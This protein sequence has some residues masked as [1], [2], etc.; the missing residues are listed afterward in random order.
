MPADSRCPVCDGQQFR[1]RAIA[2]ITIRRCLG[3]GLR[4]S[5]IPKKKTTGYATIDC[6]AYLQS[7]GRVRRAQGETIAAF[8]REHGGSGEWLDVG[9]GFGYVLEAAKAAGFRVRGIEPDPNAARAARERVGN[10]EQGLLDESTEPADVLSTLD[11]IEHLHDLNAFAELVKRK[12]RV[13]WV[14][15]VP[16]SDGLF[17]RVA[18]AL[19]IRRA[20]ERLWQAGYE[21]PHTVYFDEASLRRLL[22]KHGFDVVAVRY[23]EEVPTGTVVDR[24]TLEGTMPRWRARLAVPLF[25]AINAVERLR[26]KSDA[27]VVIARPRD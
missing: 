21:H 4:I 9:C 12:V 24:L 18:H 22:G 13:L 19:R 1:S 17:F 15:K 23:L 6:G 20:V 16:S 7:I 27:L 8:V 10:V 2:G 3:C 25:F 11:V 5:D 26:S 14:I